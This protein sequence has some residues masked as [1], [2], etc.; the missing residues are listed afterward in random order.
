MK[1]YPNQPQGY[2]VCPACGAQARRKLAKYCLDC[3]KSLQED[4]Q[5]LDNLRAS[6]RL[7]GKP[8]QLKTKEKEEPKALFKK[9]QN[10]ALELAWA[11]L[12][13]SMVPYLGILFTPGAI[14]M[15]GIG[16]ISAY[17]SPYPEKMKSSLQNIGLSLI[18]F[19]I[20]L[21]LW[22]LL[23]IIPDLKVGF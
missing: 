23:Y 1:A 3:G 15:G 19:S 10:I 13:Y 2:R 20:Q 11:F 4:Y 7:Q 14:F 17:R 9:N 22:W 6:Y 12:V 8:F 5:P 16:A 21:M 18:V